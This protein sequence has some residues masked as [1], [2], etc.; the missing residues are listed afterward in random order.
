MGSRPAELPGV[1]SGVVE[2][3]GVGAATRLET[4][5][6]KDAEV[7]RSTN[8]FVLLPT[9]AVLNSN[10]RYIIFPPDR[11]SMASR[12]LQTLY[13]HVERPYFRPPPTLATHTS[14]GTNLEI[15]KASSQLSHPP[16]YELTPT[17]SSACT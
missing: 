8:F 2:R 6:G 5:L 16:H 7:H 9:A 11:S 13:R 14:G 1:S 4:N 12:Y 15:F 10:R 3:R 17:H